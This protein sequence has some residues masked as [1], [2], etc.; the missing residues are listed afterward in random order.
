MKAAAG[1]YLFCFVVDGLVHKREKQVEEQEEW[2]DAASTML[3]A[4]LLIFAQA[5]RND[6]RGAERRGKTMLIASLLI[7]ARAL[8]L[9]CLRLSLSPFIRR[10]VSLATY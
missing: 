6:T 4:S 5:T 3:I 1:A 7:F 9:H 8:N 2:S 10:S